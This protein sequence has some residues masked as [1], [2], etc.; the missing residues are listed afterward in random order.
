MSTAT[1][2]AIE[3]PDVK[4]AKPGTFKRLMRNPSVL[5][6]G[7]ILLLIALMGLASPWLSSLN[8]AD[9]NPSNRNKLPG[10]ETTMRDDDGNKITQV[11][12]MGTDSL[13]RDIYTRVVWGARVSLTG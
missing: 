8:P 4:A 13:G 6:G 2:P 7:A 11:A 10:F 12:R 5:I 9:I 3:A 1:A